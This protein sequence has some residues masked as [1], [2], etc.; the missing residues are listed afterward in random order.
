MPRKKNSPGKRGRGWD[1]PANALS[2]ALREF[3]AWSAAHSISGA[4]LK[5]RQRALRRFILWAQDRGIT[6]PSDVT[7]PILERYQQHLYVYRKSTGEPLAFA[8]QYAELIPIR[9]FFKW[10]VRARLIL[11]NPAADLV[12]PK[13]TPNL[14]RYV[15]SVADV[16]TILNATDTATL[17]GIRDRA[18]LELLYSSGVRR[19]ELLHLRIYDVDTRRG[20]VFV[21]AGKGAKDRLVPLGDRACA[22]V[23]KYLLDVRPEL[24]TGN[25]EETLF[26]TQHGDR[27]D[28]YTIGEL[29][30]RYIAKAGIAVKGACH[31][32][33]HACATHMLENGADTRYI[34]AMLGHESLESTQIYTQVALTKLKAVHAATHP[35]RLERAKSDVGSSDEANPS[36]SAERA[37][38]ALLALLAAEG[39]EE[40]TD[41][42]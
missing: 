39:E 4:T 5:Q 42:P 36:P 16:E 24:V 6:R 13:V 17:L 2:D 25:G 1:L 14:G 27:F 38:D 20:S 15:L 23:D 34:Q 37:P 18:I 32:F 12:L 33:R 9:A 31:L 3:L 11:Y 28:D 35:A 10:L 21:K 41:A 29:V 8:S 7:L 30:K 22:W 19:S 26:L 40:Q